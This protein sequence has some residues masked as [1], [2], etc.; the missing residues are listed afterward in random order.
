MFTNVRG[1]GDGEAVDKI[2]CSS[3]P[4]S[5]QEKCV[6]VTG[7]GDLALSVLSSERPS[8]WSSSS[9]LEALSLPEVAPTFEPCAALEPERARV[10]LSPPYFQPQS[11]ARMKRQTEKQRVKHKANTTIFKPISQA[12]KCCLR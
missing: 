5:P 10:S 7:V 4:L 12:V 6:T 11:Q 1:G 3:F 9:E 2:R 8:S